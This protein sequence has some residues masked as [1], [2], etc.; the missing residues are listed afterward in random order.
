[1][2]ARANEID[3]IRLERCGWS[4][5]ALE[6]EYASGPIDLRV[7]AM[8]GGVD[9][10]QQRALGPALQTYSSLFGLAGLAIPL[11]YTNPKAIEVGCFQLED[12]DVEFWTQHHC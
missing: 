10:A 4:G 7:R 1:M 11:L 2:T 8:L 3:V 12:D 6:A 5:D 9:I